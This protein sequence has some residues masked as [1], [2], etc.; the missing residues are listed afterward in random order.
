MSLQDEIK[1]L[2]QIELFSDFNSEQ[3]NLI[4]FTSK[5]LNF[6]ADVE[7]FHEGQSASGGYV[8][9]DGTIELIRQ[10]DDKKESLGTYQT[11]SLLSELSLLTPN[12]RRVTAIT[13]K[14]TVLL[15]IPRSVIL[16]VLSEYPHLAVSIKSK[17]E[18]SI[19]TLVHNIEHVPRKLNQG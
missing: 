1:I 5:K 14:D 13:K 9:M 2:E 19:T 18:K 15:S 7:I 17:I 6:L 4:A 16:R 11:G 10:K 8:I 12:R 3:L